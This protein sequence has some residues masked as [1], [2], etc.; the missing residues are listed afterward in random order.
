MNTVCLRS[1]RAAGVRRLGAMKH[2]LLAASLLI[3]APAVE[4]QPTPYVAGLSS[5]S[6]ID[7]TARGTL[8]VT[9]AGTSLND[10]KL[11]RIAR[12]GV[13]STLVEGLPSGVDITGGASGPSGLAIQGCCLVYVLI[14]QGDVLR[15]N[16]PPREAPNPAPSVSPIF[17]S[18]LSFQ[19]DRPIEDVSD[20]FT[21]A[22]TDHETLADGAS[23]RLKNSAGQRL[24]IQM[25]SDI[26]D[27]R[28][29]PVIDHRGSN[30]YAVSQGGGLEGLLIADAGQNAIVQVDLWGPP[31]TLLRFPPVPNV[32]G[33]GPPVSDAVPTSIRHL[34]GR[35]TSCPCSA[36]FRSRPAVPA[37]VSSTYTPSR[38]RP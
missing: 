10:G 18:V 30:P 15:F 11:S 13:L 37:C 1:A 29:D 25:I 34:H 12:G 2:M 24:W 27:F 6:K 33:V 32:S 9:E 22:R 19:F 20:R 8:V 4:A 38:S 5:P 21:L 17:S 23:V 35:S 16:G 26:K 28:P 7:A 36:A 3:S 14:G 31:K